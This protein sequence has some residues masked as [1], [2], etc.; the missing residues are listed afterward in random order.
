MAV[1]PILMIVLLLALAFFAI[2]LGI[3]AWIGR[4]RQRS[5]IDPFHAGTGEGKA[6]RELYRQWAQLAYHYGIKL[7][8][9]NAYIKRIRQRIVLI[10]P[11]DEIALR[12]ETMKLIL[13]I[14]GT[15]GLTALLLVWS[16]PDWS[17]IVIVLLAAVVVSNMLV[18]VFIHRL[19]RKLLGQSVELFSVVRHH[20]QQHGMVEEAL[21]EAAESASHE[22]SLHAN[23]IYNALVSQDP[24]D[25]LER[26]YEI[27]PNRYLK[28]F[29]GISHLVMEFGDRA[30]KQGSIYLQGLSGLTKEIQLDILRRDKLDY[31][32]KGLHVIALAPV[33]FTK[34]I[35][36]WARSSFPSMDEF[37]MSKLGFV[38]KISIY[39][40]IVIS[41]ILLQKLQQHRETEYRAGLERQS[42][43]ER[44]YRVPIVRFLVRMAA[45]GIGT[46]TFHRQ[47]RLLKESNARIKF[48]WL[49]VRR[50]VLFFTVF[51]LSISLALGLHVQARHHLLYT[52]VPANPSL[53]GQMNEGERAQ[54]EKTAEQDRNVMRKMGMSPD[55]THEQVRNMISQ[56]GHTGLS[57]EQ[58]EMAMKRIMTK[59]SRYDSEYLKWWEFLLSLGMGWLAYYSPLWLLYFHRKVRN[60]EMRH[61][62]YQFQTVISILRGMERISVEGIL[63]WINRFAVIFKVPIQKCLLHYEHGAQMALEEL[64]EDVWLPEFQ[65]L[66]DKLLLAMDKVPI[67]DVFDDLEGEMIFSFEQRKQQYEAMIDTKAAWARMIGFTPMYALIFMY[68]VIPLIGMSFT[69]MEI[70]YEQIQR[71]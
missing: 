11:Y 66:V 6:L 27:A 39:V 70:Y 65:R 47:L 42:W 10:H 68:L 3:S 24:D 71:L 64:K 36:R 29:A 50:L 43:E 48:E 13:A 35:E 12:Y 28:A 2:T 60:M 4:S 23:R 41:Y 37:Y 61:E 49:Y 32:M 8:L 56:S 63:E 19:E 40:I 33:F 55:A 57:A 20:Y 31:L 9:I 46:S 59:L 67:K 38:T 52:P 69:Q 62:V 34:P 44:M 5:R 1:K 45:P 54:A 14:A 15:I 58:V 53:F 30:R 26:Y 16:R 21:Y 51:V 22:I 18:E 17:F 7:P 25:A